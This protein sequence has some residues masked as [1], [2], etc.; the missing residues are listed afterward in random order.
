MLLICVIWGVGLQGRTMRAGVI[1]K[2]SKGDIEQCNL[3]SIPTRSK[4]FPFYISFSDDR[5]IKCV[6][7][8]GDTET[9]ESPEVTTE[10]QP[11]KTTSPVQTTETTPTSPGEYEWAG[12]ASSIQYNYTVK[13]CSKAT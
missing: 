6:E 4:Y 9:T 10:E 13:S 5:P 12:V 1:H 7:D 2:W 8:D 11:D 3:M